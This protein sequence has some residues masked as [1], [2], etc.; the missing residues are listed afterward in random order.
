MLVVE[1]DEDTIRR[2][3]HVIDIGP[4][5]G[6]AAAASSRR[7]R[8]AVTRDTRSRSPGASCAHAAEASAAAAARRWPASA[9]PRSRLRG[10][11]AAQPEGRRRRVPLRRLVVV[12]GVSGSGKSTLVR[13]VLLANVQRGDAQASRREPPAG[14]WVGCDVARRLA[15]GG[16]RARG[17]PDAD[18]QD[19]ALLPGDL[20]RLLGRDPQAVR[21]DAGGQGARLRARR[22]SRSTP[23]RAAA[24]PAKARACAR[25]R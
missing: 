12:T 17:R 4:G 20:H 25:S 7:A 8:C 6:S 18:R 5:G 22:A 16:P 14:A 1:H 10:A 9:E 15:G 11:D 3:D 2:A 19:A 23:A 24:P 13:D 21:R